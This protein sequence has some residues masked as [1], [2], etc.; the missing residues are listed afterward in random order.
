MKENCKIQRKVTVRNWPHK[1][2]QNFKLPFVKKKLNKQVHRV[3]LHDVYICV[4]E[5]LYSVCWI[6]SKHCE[7]S[8]IMLWFQVDDM[9]SYMFWDIKIV[10]S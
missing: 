5:S 4:R 6:L 2:L 10:Y 3:H 8:L 9:Q 1:Y 7:A